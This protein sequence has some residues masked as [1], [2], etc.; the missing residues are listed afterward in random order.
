VFGEKDYQQLAVIRQLVRD[1]RLDVEI[2]GAPTVREP[3]G[4]ALS[5]RK[6][7]P[8]FPKRAARRSRSCARSTPRSPRSPRD[9]RDA[10]HLLA[11]VRYELAG[12]TRAQIDYAE[13]CDPT[14]LAR[15]R[16]SSKVPRCSRWRCSCGPPR[17]RDGKTVRLID[18]PRTADRADVRRTPR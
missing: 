1:L 4:L 2:V 13:L 15:A 10:A 17:A 3:D 14:T 8:R 6:P 12:A 16:A 11:L 18:K 7:P 9:E 5:S